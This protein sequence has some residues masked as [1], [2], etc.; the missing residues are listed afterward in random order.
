MKNF[1]SKQ[2]E[3]KLQVSDR[4]EVNNDLCSG[5][6]I[7]ELACSL[8][9]EDICKP[10]WSR[11][12]VK[13]KFLLLEYNPQVCTQCEWPSCYY[14]CP[15]GAVKVDLNTGARYIQADKCIGCGKCEKACPL[16]PNINVIGF[17]RIGKKK[18]Y[19][20]CDLCKDR[21]N[22]PLCVEMCPRNALSYYSKNRA[23]RN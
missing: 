8:Y 20:K 6:G 21:K 13:K 9:N 23:S 3:K 15:V 4:L 2:F 22:G 7:C 12:K 17:K 5:C 14:E 18:V 19:F 10:T 11:I 1:N 16:M